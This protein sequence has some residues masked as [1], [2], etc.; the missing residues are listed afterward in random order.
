V[1]SRL[2]SR[3]RSGASWGVVNYLLDE[4]PTPTSPLPKAIVLPFTSHATRDLG[5]WW[6]FSS[7]VAQSSGLVRTAG[8]AS[9][10]GFTEIVE[11]LVAHGCGDLDLK[12]PDDGKTSLQPACFNGLPD[13]VRVL[14]GAGGDPHL[15]DRS[16]LH[17][18]L[19]ASLLGHRQCMSLQQVS[20]DTTPS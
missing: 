4:G 13:V 19:T 3:A 17:S 8:H 7:Q 10:D 20:H 18:P 14:L 15:V 12:A 16:W 2:S 1:C 6:P 9:Y 11:L 5:T